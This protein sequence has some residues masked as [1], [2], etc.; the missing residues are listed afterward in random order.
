MTF[1]RF[2]IAG[3]STFILMYL[4]NALLVN[5]YFVDESLAYLIVNIFG[6]F[7]SHQVHSH[8]TF[9]TDCRISETWYS[10]LLG[11]LLGALIGVGILEFLLFI[12]L[13][14]HAALFISL[15][16]PA[17]FIYFFNLIIVFKR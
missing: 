8:F 15:A 2:L 7:Y 14:Y 11:V 10:F 4:S 3:G 5:Y 1:L 13:P 12:G 16:T 17:V 9:K 6:I